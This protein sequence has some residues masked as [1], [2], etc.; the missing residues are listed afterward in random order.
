AIQPPL[1]APLLPELVQ[2]AG[3]PDGWLNVI[4]GLSGEIGDVLGQDERVRMSTFTGSS[5]VGWGIAA[6][7]AKKRVRLELGNSTPVVVA[8]D[9]DLDL[10]PSKLAATAVSFA[11]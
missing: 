11:W 9:A 8:A 1:S 4:V 7:A 5:G 10:A 3:L 6:R 2:E